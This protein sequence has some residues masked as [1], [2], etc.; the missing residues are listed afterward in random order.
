MV[1]SFDSAPVRLRGW[2]ITT[3]TGERTT[4]ALSELRVGAAID[5]SLFSIQLAAAQYR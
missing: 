3:R 2:T 5:R 4:V 1:M